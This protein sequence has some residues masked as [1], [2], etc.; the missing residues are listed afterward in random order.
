LTNEQLIILANAGQR[1]I[2][3]AESDLP[4]GA[5]AT[6]CGLC[7]R[8]VDS[9]DGYEEREGEEPPAWM[10]EVF[11]CVSGCRWLAKFAIKYTLAFP[12]TMPYA[13]V[14]AALVADYAGREP[15]APQDAPN[16]S[17]AYQ[18]SADVAPAVPGAPGALQP[19]PTPA[20]AGAMADLRT[21]D[22]AEAIAAL[23]DDGEAE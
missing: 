22:I 17:E 21:S 5:T 9:E 16:Y 10:F 4:A 6:F 8:P 14:V 18:E 13:E 2:K 23:C 1:S 12:A 3:E 19:T 15:V 20:L 7:V 11:G